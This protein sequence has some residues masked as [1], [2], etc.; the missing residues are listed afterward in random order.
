MT[1][2]RMEGE[3]GNET[4]GAVRNPTDPLESVQGHKT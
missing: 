2:G 4:H 3:F 1:Q